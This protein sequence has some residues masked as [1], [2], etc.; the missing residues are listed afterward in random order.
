[1][2]LAM[3]KEFDGVVKSIHAAAL[4]PSHWTHALERIAHLH[5]SDKAL[6]STSALAPEVGGFAFPFGISDAAMHEWDHRYRKQDVWNQ[7]GAELDLPAGRAVTDTD[8]LPDDELLE[9]DFYREFLCRM[10]IGRLC[11]GMVF[12][13]RNVHLPGTR[14][15]IYGAR[16]HIFDEADRQLHSLTLDHLT[17]ALGTVER[18]RDAELRLAST[19]AALDQLPGNVLLIDRRGCVIFANAA[20]LRLLHSEDGLSLVPGNPACDALGW[21]SAPR[22]CARSELAREINLAASVD[23]TGKRNPAH[24]IK[25]QRPSGKAALVLQLS[26]LSESSAL[27][28]ADR[29]ASAIAFVTDPTAKMRID[30]DL[31]K[32]IYGFTPAESRLANNL[33]VGENLHEIADRTGVSELTLRKQLQTLFGKTY[34]RR[35]PELLKLLMNFATQ[36]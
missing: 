33:L 12:D 18:L 19:L 16:S 36:Q 2:N 22:S 23:A 7:R 5:R 3:L 8:L 26:P 15:S 24:A 17:Q 21:L 11:T 34:T 10:D 27:A 14:C 13:F 28:H 35:Q 4:A 1:M 20:A 25:L 32:Q 9:S 29:E 6:L 30:A 31:S